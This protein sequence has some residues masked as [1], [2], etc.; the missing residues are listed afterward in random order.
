[1]KLK[2]YL[3][4]VMA[5]LAIVVIVISCKKDKDEDETLTAPSVYTPM[6]VYSTYMY[7]SWSSQSGITGY[8]MDVATDPAFTS[9][10]PGYDNKDVGVKSIAEI[11]GLVPVTDYFIRVKSYNGSNE[12]GY[13]AATKVTTAGMDTVRNMDF[14]HWTQY[15]NYA[16]P[17]PHGIWATANKTRDLNPALYPATTE[18][19]TDAASGQYA[20]KMFTAQVTGL[21]LI[22]GN[23]STGVFNVNLNDPLKS[24]VTGVP[25]RTKPTGFKGYFKYHPGY[26]ATRQDSCEIRAT[27]FRWDKNLHAR[28]TIGEAIYRTS[29]S[30]K[31]YTQFNQ[32]FVYYNGNTPDSMELI[33]ASSSK[34]SYFIGNV[35]STLFVDGIELIFSK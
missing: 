20:A 24:M 9:K 13:S 21:P 6:H 7:V 32:P 22:T 8:R 14:E 34:G 33:F 5:I 15:V 10:V 2:K 3:I 19:T 11:S 23:V 28:D 12:S 31:V 27:L 30:V 29:D 4:A 1:M 35:G 16:E 17:S 26:H 25:Y 18:K